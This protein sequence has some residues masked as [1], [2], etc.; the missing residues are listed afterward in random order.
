MLGLNQYYAAPTADGKRRALQPVPR[1][2][3]LWVGDEPVALVMDVWDNVLL[4]VVVNNVTAGVRVLLDRLI[5]ET[6]DGGLRPSGS[7]EAVLNVGAVYVSARG[8][9]LLVQHLPFTALAVVR[10]LL[11]GALLEKVIAPMALIE[12]GES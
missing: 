4:G 3:K 5:L 10:Q 1:I 8:E 9:S 6:A 12:G 11:K 7:L 2:R